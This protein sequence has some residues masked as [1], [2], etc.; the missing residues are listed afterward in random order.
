M[1]LKHTDTLATVRF[2]AR[3]IEDEP[4]RITAMS[5]VVTQLGDAPE[6]EPWFLWQVMGY[7]GRGLGVNQ[8]EKQRFEDTLKGSRSAELQLLTG[9]KGSFAAV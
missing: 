4:R 7:L 8:A 9:Y 3:L 5:V 6:S 1:S 2:A